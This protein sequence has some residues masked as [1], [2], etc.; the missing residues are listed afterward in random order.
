MNESPPKDWLRDYTKNMQTALVDVGFWHTC[1]NCK[2]FTIRGSTTP[3]CLKWDQTPPPEVIVFSCVV[4]WE[5]T[6][7][8]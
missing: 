1:L 6:T 4:E 3:H 7:P 8:F 2:H 5:P